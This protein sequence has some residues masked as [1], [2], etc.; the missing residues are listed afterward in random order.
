M[1]ITVHAFIILNQLNKIN[2]SSLLRAL[3]IREKDVKT[4]K[5][6]FKGMVQRVQDGEDPEEVLYEEG[7][8]PDYIFDLL[9]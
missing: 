7:F 3:I 9:Y 5:E 2:M 8:E 4:A 6:I 1:T